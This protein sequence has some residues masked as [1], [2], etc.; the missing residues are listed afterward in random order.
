MQKTDYFELLESL[1]SLSHKS[2]RLACGETAS[3]ESGGLRHEADRLLCDCERALFS[4]FLPPLERHSIAI[5]AHALSG[6]L[7][8]AQALQSASPLPGTGNRDSYTCCL[9]LS[10]QLTEE[11]PLLRTVRKPR[12]TPNVEGFRQK[13]LAANVCHE[14]MQKQLAVGTLPRTCS[15]TVRNL[16][17]LRLALTAAF[18]TLV[19]VMLMNI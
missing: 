10:Q 17:A 3:K 6:V 13:L 8:K 18:D 16:I 2:V 11:I 9:V 12:A 7:R 14:H 15:E 1:A 5:C 19:E 4:D